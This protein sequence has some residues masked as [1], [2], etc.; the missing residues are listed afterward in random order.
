MAGMIE[1]TARTFWKIG[2]FGGALLALGCQPTP[3]PQGRSQPQVT[4]SSGQSSSDPPARVDQ[5][6]G[7]I[8][9]DACAARLQEISGALLE[10]YASYEKL[11][12]RLDVLNSLPDLDQPLASSCP[13]SD[14]PFVYVPSGLR[15]KGDP[16]LIVVY[17]PGIDRAGLRWVIRMRKP[18][19]REA[20]A[21]WVEH[22]PASSFEARTPNA[23]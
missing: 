16:R 4:V 2:V 9:S 12:A 10:Y 22:V 1:S 3:A 11:P 7:A 19:A 6:E 14:A 18:T 17:D 13:K 20:A 8:H 21:T 5:I 15:S 23:R